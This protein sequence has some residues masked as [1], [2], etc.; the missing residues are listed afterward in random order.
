[1]MTF[2]QILSDAD[3]KDNNCRFINLGSKLSIFVNLTHLY[4][5]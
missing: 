1:M 4:N 5:K 3:L 2:N